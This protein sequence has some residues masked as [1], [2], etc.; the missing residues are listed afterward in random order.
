MARKIADCRKYPS[1]INCSL[2]IIGEEEEVLRAATEH[3]VSVHQHQDTPE[4]RAQIRDLL[5]DETAAADGMSFVQL[6][7]FKTGKRA[8]LDRLLD[9]WEEATGGKR[10]ATR[11]VLAQDHEQPGS[12]YEFVEF[13]SYEEAMRNSQL[14]EIDAVS[15]KMRAICDEEPTFHN[16]DVVRAE[17]L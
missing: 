4:L 9:E 3:A 16:L 1:E 6:I 14:P 7:E 10:T 2:T 5:V 15:R 12:Y 8:E 13:P 11:A 17:A